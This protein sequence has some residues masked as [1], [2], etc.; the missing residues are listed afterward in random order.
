MSKTAAL[1]GAVLLAIVLAGAGNDKVRYFTGTV[2]D[3]QCALNIHSL[4]RSHSEMMKNKKMGGTPT[5]C[6]N[7]CVKYLGGDY[8]LANGDLVYRL[9]D[10]ERVG[11]F[12]GEKV[13]ITGTLDAKTKT[14]HVAGIEL[15]K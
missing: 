11:P 6:T 4:T 1:T 13:R 9:D 8:V 2:A 10:Q 12:A 5:A 3:S 14:I 15:A 7:Y